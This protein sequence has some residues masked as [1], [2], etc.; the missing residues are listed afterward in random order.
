MERISRVQE[1][2]SRI[3]DSTILQETRQ[4][5]AGAERTAEEIARTSILAAMV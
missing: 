2:R 1:Q 5:H 3:P 4:S